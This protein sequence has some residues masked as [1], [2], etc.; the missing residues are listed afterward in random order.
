MTDDTALIEF[1]TS[2][3]WYGSKSREIAGVRV[4]DE[5]TVAVSDEARCSIAMRGAA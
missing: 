1:I 4:V 5:V 3:R 2:Q